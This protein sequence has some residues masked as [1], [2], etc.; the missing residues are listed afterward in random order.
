MVSPQEIKMK[1]LI[2]NADDMG[3]SGAVN[4]A[5]IALYKASAITGTSVIAPGSAFSGA[6]RL[7]RENGIEEVG[8]HLTLTGN[9]RPLS[10]PGAEIRNLLTEQGFFPS[11]YLELVPRSFFARVRRA[12]LKDE[13]SRQIEKIRREGFTVTHI[14]SHEHVHMLPGILDITLELCSEFSVPYLRFPA[15]NPAVSRKRFAVKDLIRQSALSFFSAIAEKKISRAG[16]CFNS[17]FLGH[18]HS[19]RLNE[20]ILSFM[21]DKIA[22]GITELAVHPADNSPE[23]FKE[24]PWYKNGPAEMKALMSGKWQDKLKALGIKLVSHRTASENFSSGL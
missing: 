16:I 5:V 14:D 23:L 10:P 4:D 22:E 3:V 13:L 12:A 11:G 1:S 17:A 6:C 9:F 21:A 20:D 24:F 7:L 8:A 2:I 18:F 19:G 15:E